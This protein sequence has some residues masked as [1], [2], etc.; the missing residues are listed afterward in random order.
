[1]S[2]YPRTIE[3]GGGERLTFLRRTS[4]DRGEL[5][6]VES[7]VSPGSGPPMHAHHFQEEAITVKEGKIAWKE[8]GGEEHTAG[9]GETVKFAPGVSHRFWNPGDEDLVATGY[10][11]PPDNIEYFLTQIYDSTARNGGKRPGTFDGA[12]LSWHFRDEFTLTEVPGPVRRFVFPL[13]ATVGRVFGKHKRY[14]DAPEPR[15]A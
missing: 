10:I 14:A 2:D 8:E 1:M 15:R 7:R 4:D 6:E 11:R 5:L 9:P 12:Y 13:V 3:D